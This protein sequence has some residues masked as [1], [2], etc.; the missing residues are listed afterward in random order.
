MA[1]DRKLSQ[2]DTREFELSF[3][4][5]TGSLSQAEEEELKRLQQEAAMRRRATAVQVGKVQG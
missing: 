2:P 5:S 4:K 1:D 3:R